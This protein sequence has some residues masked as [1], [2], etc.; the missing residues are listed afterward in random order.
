[1]NLSSYFPS[2]ASIIWPSLSVPKVATTIASV[3]PLV[4]RALPCVFGNKSTS[5]EIFLTVLLSLPSILGFPTKIFFL[6]LY[7]I[8]NRRGVNQGSSITMAKFNGE[9]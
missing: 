2:I 7:T 1:M 6:T 3:S 4:N 9:N 5:I 8:L